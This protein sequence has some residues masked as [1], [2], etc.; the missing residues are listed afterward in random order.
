MKIIMAKSPVELKA[1]LQGLFAFPV[2]PFGENNEVDLRRYREHLQYLIDKKPSALFVCAGTGEFYSLDVN[3]YRS[4]VKAAAEEARGK[5]PVVAGI[6]YGTRLA[7]EF[8]TVA[9]EEGADG[10]M[11]MP[12]YLVQ[13]EQEGLFLHYRNI[14]TSTHL[15]IILYQRDN[16]LFTP[17]T[18]SRLAELS[19]VIGFKDGY[20]EME[21]LVRIRLVVGDRLALMNGMP[22][23][24]LS[25][26]AF[27]GV[28]VSSYS[29]AVF[30]FVPEISRAFYLS[31][32]RGDTRQLYRLID[33]FYQPFANLRDRKKGYAI[34]LIKAGVN[35]LARSVG[36]V[37]PP[38]IH[39]DPEHEAE[40]KMIVRHGLALVG[41]MPT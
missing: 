6:G 34:S 32:T 19:N 25:A 4:L 15:G 8:A 22:T 18:V 41:E 1:E 20:G 28:G 17:T 9:E 29:S 12:P 33:G 30:N 40:L 26:M 38:L 35:A 27:R 11:V 23:A 7:Q 21:R 5:L 31:L 13:S 14:A 16:A 36:E 2:T 37:R 39:P 24:E 3:E 10:L